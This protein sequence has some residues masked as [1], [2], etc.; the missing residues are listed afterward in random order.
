MDQQLNKQM[1]R[2]AGLLDERVNGN[3]ERLKRQTI[4]GVFFL[5]E[6][7]LSLRG[8]GASK[9]S[10]MRGEYVKLVSFLSEHNTDLHYRL[11]TN[12]VS[13]GTNWAQYKIT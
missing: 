4:D 6:Q 10:T 8:R 5:G 2:E 13:A 12:K 11:Y 3:R 1:P 7:E 9:E